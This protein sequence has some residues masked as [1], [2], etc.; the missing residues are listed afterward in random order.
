MR[1]VIYARLELKQSMGLAGEGNANAGDSSGMNR[2][3]I[4]HMA[5][6]ATCNQ[7]KEAPIIVSASTV[8]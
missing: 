5:I 1:C 2:V 3:D 8:G 4:I 7:M 6:D